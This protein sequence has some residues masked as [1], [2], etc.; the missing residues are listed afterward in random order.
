MSAAA[1]PWDV[2]LRAR[3]VAEPAVKL[4]VTRE[5][6]KTMQLLELIDTLG[7]VTTMR[8]CLETDLDSRA[9]WGLLK[10]HRKSGRVRF[11]FGEWM[12]GESATSLKAR[13]AAALLRALGWTV[14]EPKGQVA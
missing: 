12:P 9:V 13:Q 1:S 3:P 6:T 8:L 7:Y 2:L 10:T 14:V 5:G 4:P 11:L